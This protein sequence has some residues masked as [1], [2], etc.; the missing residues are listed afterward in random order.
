MNTSD[1]AF[2]EVA[3]VDE[4]DVSIVVVVVVAID[5]EDVEDEGLK[6]DEEAVD[7][8]SRLSKMNEV[9]KHT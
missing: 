6:E 4:I 9:G 8:P 5:E 3:K 1:D 7:M 2:D